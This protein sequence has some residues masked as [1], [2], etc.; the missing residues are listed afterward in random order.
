MLAS[1]LQTK[2]TT[3]RRWTVR[4]C[5]LLTIIG[6]LFILLDEKPPPSNQD[7]L[8]YRLPSIFGRYD[9]DLIS[10]HVSSIST[11]LSSDKPCNPGYI[12]TIPDGRSPTI[13]DQNGDLIWQERRDALTQNIR[14]QTFRGQDYLTYWTK[15]QFG[16]GR[17]D[18][19]NSLSA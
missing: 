3:L 11:E 15:E 12:F 1:R 13:Y 17:F 7:L 8:Q 10:P 5:A 6:T 19:V 9:F 2:P 18:M 16:P 14:V 4:A